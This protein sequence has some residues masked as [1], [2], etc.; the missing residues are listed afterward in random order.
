MNEKKIIRKQLYKNMLFNFIAFAIIFSIFGGVTFNLIKSTMYNQVDRGLRSLE[1]FT[2]N[3]KLKRLDNVNQKNNSSQINNVN[4]NNSTDQ[5][6]NSDHAAPPPNRDNRVDN[7]RIHTIIRD[8]DGKAVNFINIG[9]LASEK[10][11]D[12]P[13]DLNN[14]DIVHTIIVGGQY[15]YRTLTFRA[16]I[17]GTPRYVQVLINI[18]GEQ[19]IL[20][21]YLK[22]IIIIISVL[23]ILAISASYI[24]SRVTMRPIISAWER[25]T[26]F[27]QD[28]SH[29][30][31]T[32]LSI[33]QN[34]L[35]MMLTTPG[36]KI[37]DKSESIALALSE[38]RRLSKLTADLM[39]LA[40]YDSAKQMLNYEEFNLDKMISEIS[41]PYAEIG[42]EQE[43]TFKLDLRLESKVNA[44]KA[45]IHQLLVILLDNALKY[46]ES[47]NTITVSSYKGDGKNVIE[48]ADTGIGISDAGLSHIFERFYREDK[49]RSRENGGTGLGLSI[50]QWIVSAHKGSIK[51]R[52][53]EPQG[54]IFTVKLP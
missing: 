47:G 39:T 3:D 46:T 7:P 44:D 42:I 34:K 21:N 41:E 35:E 28:A 49:A 20:N 54:I 23:L 9:S 26:R 33:I 22:I 45:R 48:V 18:D 17:N 11:N 27:V 15:Y 51:A 36:S 4:Q 38:T 10:L 31:R 37:V 24:L 30:L 25:Q 43:K 29:E 2:E 8:L 32:P 40:Q 50:A 5:P 19:A 1:Q 53:N 14:I 13:A 52:H 6:G 16:T 12:L